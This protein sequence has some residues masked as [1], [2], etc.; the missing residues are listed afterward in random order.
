MCVPRMT[1]VSVKFMKFQLYD[2]FQVQIKTMFKKMFWVPFKLFI[3]IGI[4]SH[5]QATLAAMFSVCL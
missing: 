4:Q 5:V 1:V 3:I 2:Q